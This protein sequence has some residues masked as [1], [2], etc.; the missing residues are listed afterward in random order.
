MPF[1]EC[2][3]LLLALDTSITEK[4]I[5]LY[6]DI[7]ILL[8]FQDYGQRTH[9]PPERERRSSCPVDETGQQVASILVGVIL[10]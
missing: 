1:P 10:E 8:F 6:K 3:L 9:L 5:K 4:S 2:T 7:T